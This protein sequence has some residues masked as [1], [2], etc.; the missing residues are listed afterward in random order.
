MRNIRKAINPDVQMGAHRSLSMSATRRACVGAALALSLLSGTHMVGT[1][2]ALA[3]PVLDDG[4]PPGGPIP[5]SPPATASS[6]DGWSLVLAANSETRF[7][8]VRLDP[9]I[10]S[11]DYV[12]SGVFTGTLRSATQSR[13]PTPKGTLEVGYQVQ[14]VGGGLVALARPAA[15]TIPVLKQ[16]FADADPS[17]TVTDF[18]VQVNCAGPAFLRSYATLSRGTKAADALVAYYGISTPV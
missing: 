17:V 6:P 14:C 18:R 16:E 11:R 7:A 4:A 9:N 10:P 5:S 3:E 13:T 15:V 12:V 1:G 2:R 8:T